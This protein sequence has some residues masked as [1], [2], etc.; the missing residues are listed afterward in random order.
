METLY[1]QAVEKFEMGAY[2][3]HYAKYGIQVDDFVETFEGI[4]TI[5]DNYAE[6]RH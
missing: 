2:L 1:Q 5:C 6:W 3:H 4:Q